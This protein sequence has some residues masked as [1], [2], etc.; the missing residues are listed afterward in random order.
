MH[1]K[2]ADEYKHK[3]NLNFCHCSLVTLVKASDD[4]TLGDSFL[5]SFCDKLTSSS[6]VPLSRKNTACG[7]A[8]SLHWERSSREVALAA[9]HRLTTSAVSLA[10]TPIRSADGEECL[11]SFANVN[12]QNAMRRSSEAR[13]EKMADE[14]ILTHC[15]GAL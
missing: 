7:T 12:G 11:Q 3:H 2:M 15:T 5:S 10:M 4:P 14:A 8:V 1:D 9:S 6:V 13:Q